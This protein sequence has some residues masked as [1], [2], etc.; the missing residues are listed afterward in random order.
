MKTSLSRQELATYI[1]RLLSHY[2]PDGAEQLSCVGSFVNQSL[3]RIEHCFSHINKKYYWDDSG[4]SFD[5]LHGDHMASFLYF[6]G[7]VIWRETGDVLVP[8]KL[9]YLN[10]IMHGLDLFFS[11]QMPDIF[12]LVHPVGTVLG[13]AKYQDYLVVYQNCTVGAVTDIYP[14]FGVGTVLYSRS[15]VLGDCHLGNDVVCAANSMVIDSSVPDNSVVVGQYPSHRILPNSMSIR[16]RC[17]G[18]NGSNA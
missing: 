15:S 12:V 3:D 9:S 4:V 16:E 1:E 14:R 18:F 10:K 11:V 6:L 13:N 8:T 7:N 2:I 17:F 5:H